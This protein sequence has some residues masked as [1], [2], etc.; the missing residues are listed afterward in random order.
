MSVSRS[1]FKFFTDEIDLVVTAM[2][3]LYRGGSRVSQ[4]SHATDIF[5]ATL[6]FPN[7]VDDDLPDVIAFL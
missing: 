5:F 3:H 7:S 4:G 1:Y 2:D 6:N